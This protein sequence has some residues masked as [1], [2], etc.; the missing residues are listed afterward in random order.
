MSPPLPRET[1]EDGSPPLTRQAGFVRAHSGSACTP[2]G[3][4]ELRH[5]AGSGFQCEL[6]GAGGVVNSFEGRDMC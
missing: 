6:W 2:T 3:S 4:T 5:P 1:P